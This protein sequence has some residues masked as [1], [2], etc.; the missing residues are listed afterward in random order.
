MATTPESTPMRFTMPFVLALPMLEQAMMS[1][2]MGMRRCATTASK[3]T[4][5]RNHSCTTHSHTTTCPRCSTIRRTSTS[6]ITCTSTTNQRLIIIRRTTNLLCSSI[7]RNPTR[8]S[9]SRNPRRT[10]RSRCNALARSQVTDDD[11]LTFSFK[12]VSFE[13]RMDRDDDAWRAS[14][15]EP[16]LSWIFIATSRETSSPPR[17]L[18]PKTAIEIM[19]TRA[20]SRFAR[21]RMALTRSVA[22][23]TTIFDGM[24]LPVAP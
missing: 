5:R 17:T 13:K 1:S 3:K 20:V 9:I 2:T 18:L 11:V 15:S 8:S 24:P 6:P 4:S 12:S 21:S 16:L 22:V 10:A 14:Q 19:F 7:R 23:S